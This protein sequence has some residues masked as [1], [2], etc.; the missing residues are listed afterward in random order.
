MSEIRIEQYFWD[1]MFIIMY[2]EY[3]QSKRVRL[4]CDGNSFPHYAIYQ[5][6]K[7]KFRVMYEETSV[8]IGAWTLT[9]AINQPTDQ[10]T[11]IR[12]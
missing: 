8:P 4:D 11:N 1:T 6:H 12:T 10:P 7:N 3:D 9:Q 5:F 2:I